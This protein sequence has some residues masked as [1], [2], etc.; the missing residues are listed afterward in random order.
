M[1]EF[2]LNFVILA[3]L[4]GFGFAAGDLHA[5][6]DLG[7]NFML[8]ADR[9]TQGQTMPDTN[10]SYPTPE[11]IVSYKL[12]ARNLF[13]GNRLQL[14]VSVHWYEYTNKFASGNPAWFIF[15]WGDDPGFIEHY[16]GPTDINNNGRID[17]QEDNEGNKSSLSDHVCAKWGDYPSR[18]L[19]LQT[20]WNITGKDKVDFSY[21]YMDDERTDLY[22]EYVYDWIY[23]DVDISG[24]ININAPKHTIVFTYNHNFILRNG[25]SLNTRFDIRYQTDYTV[26]LKN[27][28]S[29]WRDQDANYYI[30]DLSL[31]YAHTDGKWTLTGYVKNIEN[32]TVKR[33]LLGAGEDTENQKMI[34]KMMIG[35]PRT[36]GALLSIR[37]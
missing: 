36:Y 25:A 12:G 30:S 27:A 33:S 31:I 3:T 35:A 9:S 34:H 26:S 2:G 14:N 16:G 10:G 1:R 21:S 29:L 13:M 18:G 15:M 4:L 28:D 5:G 17:T 32:Y 22:Y 19:D 6:Y 24:A 11:E 23:P 20:S 7:E 37:Y 8:Y